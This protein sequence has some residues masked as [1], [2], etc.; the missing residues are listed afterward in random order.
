MTPTP[1]ITLGRAIQILRNA[2]LKYTNYRGEIADKTIYF[3]FPLIIPTRLSSWRGVYAELAIGYEVGG[4]T[5]AKDFLTQ[6]EDADGRTF[7]GWKGGD[8]LM[9][10]ETPL[11]VSNEGDAYNVLVTDI[12]VDDYQVTIHTADSD[13]NDD[14]REEIYALPEIF[15]R[16]RKLPVTIEAV[17]YTGAQAREIADWCG[18]HFSEPIKAGKQT[19]T[20]FHPLYIP[21]LEGEMTADEGDYIIKGVKGEFYPCKSDIF[22]LTYEEV[23]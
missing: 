6:L 10:E 14:E 5:Y 8:Y 13:Y 19:I 17:K 18:G 9:S 16:Y 21:T 2:D 1:H 12:T 4:S 3:D 22:E 20:A 23:N 15:K 7:T 11:W